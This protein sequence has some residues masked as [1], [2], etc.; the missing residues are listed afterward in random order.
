MVVMG[1]VVVSVVLVVVAID[2]Q[3]DHK[4]DPA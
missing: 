1:E 2:N 4:C 3:A